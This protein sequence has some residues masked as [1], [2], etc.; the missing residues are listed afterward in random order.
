MRSF[1]TGFISAVV[2]CAFAIIYAYSTD[3]GGLREAAVLGERAVTAQRELALEYRRLEEEYRIIRDRDI[4][5]V[6]RLEQLEGQLSAIN[7]ST[8][9]IGEQIAQSGSLTASSRRLIAEL[10]QILR[11]ATFEVQDRKETSEV[12]FGILERSSSISYNSTSVEDIL[13]LTGDKR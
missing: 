6:K 3:A 4:K 1:I 10:D 13:F 5:N 11:R 8:R 2:L 9:I 7:S 12:D